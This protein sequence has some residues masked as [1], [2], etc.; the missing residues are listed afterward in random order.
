MSEL[1]P[2]EHACV[3]CNETI[4][5]P[6]CMHCLEDEIVSWSADYNPAMVEDV[7]STTKIMPE[8]SVTGMRCIL[9]GRDIDVCPHCYSKDVFKGIKDPVLADTFVETFNFDLR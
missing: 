2:N 9:C 5:N 3:I 8:P 4:T 1:N 6:V 7:V